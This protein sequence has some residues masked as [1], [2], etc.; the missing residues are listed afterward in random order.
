MKLLFKIT[1]VLTLVMILTTSF[2]PSG[3]VADLF[4]VKK[5]HAIVV[6][7]PGNLVPNIGDLVANLG[8][9]VE[10][11]V[12][13]VKEVVVAELKKQ[14]LDAIVNQ[15]IE[16]IQGGGK[17]QF[18]TDT[19]GFL[20]NIEAQAIDDFVGKA[21]LRFLCSPFNLQLRVNLF[22]V[23]RFGNDAPVA[24]TLDKIVGNINNFYN[25]FHTGGWIAFHQSYQPQNNFY[26]AFL[27]SQTIK[28][29]AVHEAVGNALGEVNQ[30]S[31]F[32]TT[33]DCEEDP[34]STGPDIDHDRSPGDIYLT[35]K[36]S[37]P[38]KLAGDLV[39]KGIGSDIDFIVNSNDLG[40]YVAAIVDAAINRL[41]TSGSSGLL[42]VSGSQTQNVDADPCHDLSGTLLDSCRQYQQG[43]QESAQAQAD[44]IKAQ[45]EPQIAKRQEADALYTDT[46]SQIDSY[47]D[48]LAQKLAQFIHDGCNAD[49]TKEISD[50][51]NLATSTLVS[52]E[53]SRSKNKLVIDTI[54]QNMDELYSAASSTSDQE[55]LRK[56]NKLEPFLLRSDEARTVSQDA[57]D[58][59]QIWSNAITENKKKFDDATFCL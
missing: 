56:V 23:A 45:L 50:E 11:I 40:G 46:I 59:N 52:L 42:G 19:K 17:P 18:V 49:H 7:D 54:L 30:G 44:N 28:N 55:F 21:G 31:G 58:N 27:I 32:L 35:C 3:D 10:F 37:T 16:W 24:C 39:S 34:A 8:S 33:K 38:G 47:K 51:L 13:V 2:A 48:Y 1:T 57:K 36:I 4:K 14:I 22:P 9:L 41:V 26:G 15:I 25:N 43:R 29:A 5:V 20:K 12:K 6:E 53:A